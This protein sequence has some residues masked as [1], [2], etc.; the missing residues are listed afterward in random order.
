[1]AQDKIRKAIEILSHLAD[2]KRDDIDVDNRQDSGL[3]PGPSTGVRS[4]QRSAGV[5]RM[6]HTVAV[7]RPKL[8]PSA[9]SCD[10]GRNDLYNYQ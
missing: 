1:M 4:W 3:Q 5:E 10:K 6:L 9:T 2:H 7:A 8:T